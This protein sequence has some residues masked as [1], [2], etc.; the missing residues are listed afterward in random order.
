MT[1]EALS[2]LDRGDE[3]IR[4]TTEGLLEALELLQWGHNKTAEQ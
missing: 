2:S 1:L 3:A 4:P